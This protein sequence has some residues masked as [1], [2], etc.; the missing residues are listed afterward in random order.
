MGNERKKQAKVSTIICNQH[1]ISSGTAS[2]DSTNCGSKILGKKNPDTFKKQNLNLRHPRNYLHSLHCIRY[3]KKSRDGQSIGAS[4]SASALPT[5]FQ[6]WL[7]LWL[8]ENSALFFPESLSNYSFKKF[9]LKRR[10]D[11]NKFWNYNL[12]N[13]WEKTVEDISC[14]NGIPC[15]W[16]CLS[17]AVRTKT[18]PSKIIG[19]QKLKEIISFVRQI[20]QDTEKGK[21]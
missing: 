10:V 20:D 1:S 14:W 5:N 21:N 19:I 11:Q 9:V 7:P 16:R 8:T 17:R 18:N 12:I 2:I 3:Y 6:S 15:P 13:F 4:G